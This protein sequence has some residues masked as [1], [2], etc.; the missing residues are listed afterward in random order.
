MPIH[1][2]PEPNEIVYERGPTLSTDGRLRTAEPHGIFDNKN[3]SS[4]NQNQWEEML[5][6]V[7]IQYTGLVGA[8]TVTEEIRGTLPSGAIAIGTI[9]ADTGSVLTIDCNHND[10]QVGDTITGQT[11]G[12]TATVSTTNTG[13]DIQHDYDHASVVLTVGTGASD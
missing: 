6:G 10:F 5:S 3:I 12:A 11:S 13:S 7:I 1:I 4:R 8:F 9:V 2:Y